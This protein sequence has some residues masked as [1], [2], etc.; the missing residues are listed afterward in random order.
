MDYASVGYR[1]EIMWT[2]KGVDAELYDEADFNEPPIA[3]AHG[4]TA[5]KAVKKLFEKVTITR[6]DED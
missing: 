2:P 5:D 1:V 4:K 3:S 6:P